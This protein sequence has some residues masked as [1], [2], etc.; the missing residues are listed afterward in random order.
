MSKI[1]SV[2]VD[3]RKWSFK[4]QLS[5][6]QLWSANYWCS[7]GDEAELYIS[8]KDGH[9][10]LQ[11]FSGIGLSRIIIKDIEFPYLQDKIKIDFKEPFEVQCCQIADYLCRLFCEYKE[12]VTVI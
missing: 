12:D 6:Y 5:E 4:K 3:G 9:L 7:D 2:L 11:C 1:T 10:E 8:N